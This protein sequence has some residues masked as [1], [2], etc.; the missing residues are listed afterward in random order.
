MQHSSHYRKNLFSVRIIFVLALLV[1]ISL[2]GSA[3]SGA[4]AIPFADIPALLWGQ[5]PESQRLMQAV[6]LDIR[7]PRVLFGLVA[8]AA[9]ALSG[10]VMQALFRN[11]LAEPG[12]IGVSS[13]AALGAVLVIVLAN[14]GFWGIALAAFAGSLL[15]TWLAYWVGCR[16][17]GVAG[18]LLA[19]IAINA[20]T[21]S[22]IGLLSYIATDNELRDLTFWSMGSLA[23][24]SWS[25]LGFMLPW[26]VVLSVYAVRQWKALNALLLG[27]REVEHL[28]FSMQA[29]R[30]RLI[31]CVALLIGPL[32][33]VTGGIGFVGLV[34]PHI[35]RMII[36]A[37]HRYLLPASFLG[38][39]LALIW[40][41]WV[42]RTII[43][44]S[45]LPIGLVTS[46]IG[47]PFFLWLLIRQ[48]K[49]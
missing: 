40:A 23:A 32:V 31:V 14:T 25:T 44:P 2:I 7:L 27:E 24:A 29:L 21:G 8:G 46:L 34:V 15:C 28:G 16:F 26:T 17:P 38:G 22:L 48:I 9:L 49:R 43:L 1:V 39:G 36:G 11:P 30:R 18:L 10:V 13:G 33:A 12:L 6:L 5:V 20:I 4:V 19:G 35:M 42:A 47:G 3:S 37:N 45:E 41:D